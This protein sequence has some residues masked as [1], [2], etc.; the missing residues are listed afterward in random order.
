MNVFST[1]VKLSRNLALLMLSMKFF[2][3]AGS[4][5][6]Q[7][8]PAFEGINSWVCNYNQEAPISDLRKFD[9][10]ILDADAHPDLTA[11]K[12]TNTI[13][14][15][16]VSLGEVGDYRWY[17]PSISEK[18]WILGKN[19]NW[20]SRMIDVRA[21]EWHDWL[22]DKII[23]RVLEEGFDGLF[24]DTIDNAEYLEKYHPGKKYPGAQKAMIHLIK[25]IRRH[26]PEI[27]IV[28]NRGFAILDGIGAVIDGVVAESIFTNINFTPDDS[29]G[30]RSEQDYMP[31]IEQLL[32][33]KRKYNLT[34]FTL[35]YVDAKN[36][37]DIRAVLHQSRRFGFK[38]YISDPELGITYFH[39]L[40]D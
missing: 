1:K 20:N 24:L 7:N 34:V 13:L 29:F 26:F 2:G 11:L 15:G 22:I 10:A 30:A 23:P 5:K 19:P 3:C 37:A 4:A 28:A 14:I 12:S 36:N 16:Y 27:F 21:S 39:T 31:V 18:P 32:R 40:E 25:S 9:L 8:R 17:W 38:P 35:D 6:K 33:A